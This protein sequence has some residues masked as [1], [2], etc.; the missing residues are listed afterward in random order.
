MQAEF[1]NE[2][3]RENYLKNVAL[4]EKLDYTVLKNLLFKYLKG[5]DISKN[6][7]NEYD[8][9]ILGEGQ[10]TQY[11]LS[12]IDSNFICLIF[13]LPDKKDKIKSIIS[14]SDL[15]NEAYKLLYSYYLTDKKY[16]DIYTL[17]SEKSDKEKE[18]VN[19]I[20]NDNYSYDE[21]NPNEL[22]ES[23]NQIIKQIKIRSLKKVYNENTLE[24]RFELK[25]KINEINNTKFI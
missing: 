7:I 12:K 18:F 23:L 21:N 16:S 4:Q 19:K 5:N 8:T 1:S 10:T 2:F 11:E 14:D 17:I 9:T 13:L 22:L 25:N 20:L 24:G 15:S 6:N 3:V